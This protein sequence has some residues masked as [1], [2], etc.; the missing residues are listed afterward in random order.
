[1]APICAA[2][3]LVALGVA[4][5]PKRLVLSSG[6]LCF[7][8]HVGVL[9]ALDAAGELE[10]GK[11]GAI[12]GTSSGAIVGSMLAAG[13]GVDE[14]AALVS[15]RRPLALC[16]PTLRPWRGLFS[17][18]RLGEVLEAVLPERFEDLRT[19]L[20]V[21]VA[22]ADRAGAASTAAVLSAGP[23]V[24]AILAS[25]AVPAMF[26]PV[27]VGGVKY[28]DGGIVDR[29][30]VE[31]SAPFWRGISSAWGGAGASE[32][33]TLVHLIS[34]RP[35]VEL[36]PRDGITDAR[37]LTIIRTR[38]TRQSL[39][40]RFGAVFDEEVARAAAEC[41]AVL[42]GRAASASHR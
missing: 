31:V 7:S 4:V 37:G 6:F 33:A 11:L 21:G 19:P 8:N 1:M 27:A 9:R 2:I 18:S 41:A 30:C 5:Q 28:V 16:R 17:A 24:P 10:R 12:V 36:G 15:A 25:C 35:D 40:R 22:R 38:R 32:G 13:M 14:I 39:A 3:A 29:T 34:D 26:Q 23:L 42:A 20:A